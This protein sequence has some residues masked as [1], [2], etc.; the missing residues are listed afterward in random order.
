MAVLIRAGVGAI[1]SGAAAQSGQITG[2]FAA[3]ALGVTAPL[4]IEKL[5]RQAS[6]AIDEKRGVEVPNS[7]QPSIEW[8][9][10]EGFI[11]NL[12]E[13]NPAGDLNAS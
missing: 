12:E 10:D 9:K 8:N 3:V 1:L 6:V 4:V 7:R 5:A 13:G 11:P 2:A